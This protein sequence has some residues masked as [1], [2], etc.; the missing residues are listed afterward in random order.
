MTSKPLRAS[1]SLAR[2][3]SSRGS[4]EKVLLC[5]G[6]ESP[7]TAKYPLKASLFHNIL[8][9]AIF[10]IAFA[11]YSTL[12]ILEGKYTRWLGRGNVTIKGKD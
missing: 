6:N 12:A 5:L 1:A 9:S 11:R 4:P 10:G 7:S 3:L 8:R 2:S